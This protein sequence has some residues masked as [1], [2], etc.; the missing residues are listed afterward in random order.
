MDESFI[1]I[2]EKLYNLIKTSKDSIYKINAINRSKL[3]LGIDTFRSF[4]SYYDNLK[5]ANEAGIVYTPEDIANYIIENIITSEDI[6]KNPF[7]RIIDPS[8]GVGNIL[9][10]CFR[11]LKSIYTDNLKVINSLNNLNLTHTNLMDHILKNNLFGKDI[12]GIAIKI[13]YIDMF[14]ESKTISSYNF[15]ENDFLLDECN[16]KYDVFIGNPPYIGHKLIDKEYS[17]KLREI[18]CN[19]YKDKSDISFCF[20]KKSLQCSSENCKISYITSRYFM[21]SQNGHSLRELLVNETNISAIVDFYGDRPFKKVGIDPVIVFLY[22][23]KALE[24]NKEIEVLR[25]ANEKLLLDEA[26]NYA[27]IMGTVFSV[28]NVNRKGLS[29]GPWILKSQGELNIINKIISK[30]KY[31]LKDICMSHQGIITGCDKA[32]IVDEDII[33]QREL[34]KEIVKPWIKSCNIQQGYVEKAK[35]YIIYSNLISDENKYPNCVRYIENYRSKLLTRRECIKGL[36]K[37]YE[38][39]WGRMQDIFEKDKIIFPYKCS[40]NKFVRNS[41]NYFSADIYALT[42]QKEALISYDYLV[43][44]LNSKIYEY[45]FKS[46]AKKLGRSLYEYYP[47]NLMRLRIPTDFI[48]KLN[49]EDAL[50][51]YFGITEEEEKVINSY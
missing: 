13:L 27:N 34:E 31:E 10:P 28:T 25:R 4:G 23:N 45:Y 11:Y 19:L 22:G 36:R 42:I 29:S 9:I 7:I 21:E 18:F 26:I 47:N 44:I 46:Y 48:G 6:I 30:C 35:K 17:L 33:I 43:Y 8:C 37:W 41:G 1:K 38:L 39:Q 51:D 16:D 24:N 3:K 40:N 5:K 12:D 2:V 20:F 15:Y 14:L 49:S 32:F 50:Y